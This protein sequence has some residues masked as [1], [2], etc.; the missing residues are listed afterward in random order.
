MPLLREVRHGVLLALVAGL[1][2]GGQP[3]PQPAAELW[4]RLPPVELLHASDLLH[5]PGE[6]FAVAEEKWQAEAQAE[7][8]EVASRPIT[9][10][11]AARWVGRP[12]AGKGP[13][14]LLRAICLSL[15]E[16]TFDVQ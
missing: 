11:Q 6:Q 7:L 15:S 5:L 13:L 1:G 14:V 8:A 12:L 10:E 2:C 9:A 3:P 16:K 4:V